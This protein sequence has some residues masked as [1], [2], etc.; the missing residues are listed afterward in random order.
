MP[1]VDI[2]Y[3]RVCGLCDKAI[4]FFCKRGVTFTAHAVEWDAEKQEF[5]DS[6]AA[7]EM[8]RRCGEKVDFVPQ[9]F[10]G[11]Q[12]IKGWRKLKPMIKS[13]EIDRLVPKPHK[14]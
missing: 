12:H 2:Y 3:A 7:R 13:G 4:E 8:Y 11:D 10:I 9:I 6:Q 5:V 14:R 1:E